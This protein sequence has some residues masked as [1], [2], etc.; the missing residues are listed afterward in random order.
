MSSALLLRSVLPRTPLK[1][2]LTLFVGTALGLAC[3][4][5]A[6]FAHKLHLFASV[7]G[8]VIVG[9]VYYSQSAPYKHGVVELL[10]AEQK[11][12][13]R[14]KSDYE[15][16]FR[17]SIPASLKGVSRARLRTKSGDGHLV[18]RVIHLVQSGTPQTGFQSG[19]QEGLQGGQSAHM[20]S[21]HAPHHAHDHDKDPHHSHEAGARQELRA[22]LQQELRPLKEDLHQLQSK[23]WLHEILGGLGLLCGFFGVW[24]FWLAR[25]ATETPPD[26]EPSA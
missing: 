24:M 12:I 4:S 8:D 5:G 22:V 14:T 2:L 10:S 13:A 21:I 1:F 20:D 15:G 25:R 16:R 3:C 17:L 11:L 18:E 23:I 6:A 9:R 19:L 26:T 7:E